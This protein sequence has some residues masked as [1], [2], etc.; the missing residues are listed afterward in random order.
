L[1]GSSL[2]ELVVVC[3]QI[4]AWPTN[5]PIL[6][7]E[8]DSIYPISNYICRDITKDFTTVL[9]PDHPYNRRLDSPFVRPSEMKFGWTLGNVK[10]LDVIWANQKTESFV[11]RWIWALAIID[12]T[13]FPALKVHWMPFQAFCRYNN[14]KT[15][16][17]SPSMA[18]LLFHFRI[19][20]FHFWKVV[21][22]HGSKLWH[23]GHK[24]VRGGVLSEV[25]QLT[26]YVLQPWPQNT[27]LPVQ[28]SETG[29]N[30]GMNFRL[31][32]KIHICSFMHWKMKKI[33]KVGLCM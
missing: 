33:P 18:Y 4:N 1:V 8:S 26:I 27:K 21:C 14:Y 9:D 17:T 20:L 2:N 5:Q 7:S 19:G 12:V 6:H 22:S 13:F 24:S 28:L 25:R 10:T 32:I 15:P 16:I 3:R 31:N 23:H 29:N 11:Y 30:N